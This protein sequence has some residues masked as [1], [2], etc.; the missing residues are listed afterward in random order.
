MKISTACVALTQAW[1]CT[2]FADEGILLAPGAVPLAFLS[3]VMDEF[4]AKLSE[5]MRDHRLMAT[6]GVLVDDHAE[7]RIRP[8]RLGCPT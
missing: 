6:G 8:C 7:G 2:E 3:A 1:Q 5:R 4:G